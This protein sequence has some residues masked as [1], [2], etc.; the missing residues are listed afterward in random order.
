MKHGPPTRADRL[1]DQLRAELTR[2]LGVNALDDPQ[3]ALGLLRAVAA[4][5]TGIATEPTAPSLLRRNARHLAGTLVRNL[6][7]WSSIDALAELDD[8]GR[9]KLHLVIL[10]LCMDLPVTA[11]HLA[12]SL[13][14]RQSVDLFFVPFA[15]RAI[16][17]GSH[18]DGPLPRA[19]PYLRDIDLSDHEPTISFTA[20]RAG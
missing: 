14:V 9:R 12:G 1:L 6:G 17:D 18:F 20:L 5:C 8:D 11:W 2:L 7:R 10:R 15:R 13:G 3:Q 4:S 19:L 16:D